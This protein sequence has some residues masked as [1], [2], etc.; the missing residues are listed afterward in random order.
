MKKPIKKI[1]LVFVFTL[2]FL[3]ALSA[4]VYA[5]PSLDFNLGFSNL[6]SPYSNNNQN[7]SVIVQPKDD[8]YK[9][10]LPSN[11]R[12]GVQQKRTYKLFGSNGVEHGDAQTFELNKLKAA[13]EESK[14][15]FINNL[16]AKFRNSL[17]RKKK[18]FLKWEYT[19]TNQVNYF[20]IYR[21][22]D[23]NNWEQ[24]GKATA[25]KFED[26]DISENGKYAYRVTA[27]Y[28]GNNEN[29]TGEFSSAEIT[30][31]IDKRS[32]ITLF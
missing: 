30:I 25:T 8:S 27:F 13:E 1:M 31:N 21:R 28:P 12:W 7:P 29:N 11:Y 32:G 26:V 24:I 23:E 16:N 14:P 15:T 6:A 17:L 20:I 4:V 5:F 22:I 10:Q 2:L 19:G 9:T 3:L 18:V